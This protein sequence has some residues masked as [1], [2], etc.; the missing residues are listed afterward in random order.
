M[1][2]KYTKAVVVKLTVELKS[3]VFVFLKI[4]KVKVNKFL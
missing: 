2:W 1:A 4:K 3:N